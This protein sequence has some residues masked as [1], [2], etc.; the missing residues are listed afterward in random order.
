MSLT[1]V[2]NILR[3]ALEN[4][5]KLNV[6]CYFLDG[7]FEQTLVDTGH[8]IYGAKE[9]FLSDAGRPESIKYIPRSVAAMD[10]DIL[11]DLVVFNH[12]E[13]QGTRAINIA[14]SLHV[15]VL[16]IQHFLSA[17]KHIPRQE[18]VFIDESVRNSFGVGGDVIPY[19]VKDVGDVGGDRDIDVLLHGS[20][21][22]NDYAVLRHIQQMQFTTEIWGNNPGISVNI[23]YEDL[24]EKLKR[25]KIFL[26]LST[27][28]GVPYSAI[29]A[30]MCGCCIVSNKNNITPHIFKEEFSSIS[31]NLSKFAPTINDLMDGE[32][33]EKGLKA[34]KFAL[35]KYDYNKN[36]ASWKTKLETKAREVY[37]R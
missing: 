15:P 32:W 34:R 18:M 1:P 14:N 17:I 8:N 33:K 36:V 21:L 13:S 19:G 10:K 4:R 5:E 24:T 25:T 12:L 3:A 16:G 7:R 29:L 35:E 22:Q 23:S 28:A 27:H 6:L 2:S 26:N 30:M 31:E 11:F 37:I 20:F 9:S